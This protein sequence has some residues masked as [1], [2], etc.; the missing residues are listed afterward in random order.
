MQVKRLGVIQTATQTPTHELAGFAALRIFVADIPSLRGF[1][2]KDFSDLLMRSGAGNMK[3]GVLA[4]GKWWRCHKYLTFDVRGRRS[5]EGAEGTGR[6]SL[7]AVPLDGIVSALS[8][9]NSG[10]QRYDAQSLCDLI[11]TRKLATINKRLAGTPIM[12][13]N[14]AIQ[15]VPGIPLVPTT[16]INIISAGPGRNNCFIR[17]SSSSASLNFIL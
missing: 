15:N 2:P 13:K 6:R 16:P 3:V 12:L 1:D 7:P 14:M 10:P 8:H 11:N 4:I 17:D 5:A 9:E